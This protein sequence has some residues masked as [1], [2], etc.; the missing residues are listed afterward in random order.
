MDSDRYLRTP[1]TSGVVD[2]ATDLAASAFLAHLAL[3]PMLT[4]LV[5]SALLAHALMP[6]M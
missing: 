6:P 4:D 2:R 5:A 1:R 3:P